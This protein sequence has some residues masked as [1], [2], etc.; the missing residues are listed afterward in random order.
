MKAHIITI[1]NEIL[2]G[3]I[4]DSNSAF[5]GQ[6]L[7]EIG[8]EVHQI[9]SISDD[10]AHI[11][12]TLQQN[13]AEIVILTGGLGPTKDDITKKTLAQFFDCDLIQNES[14]LEHIQ[15]LFKEVYKREM[16]ALN[17]E[18][19]LVPSCATVLFNTI[20]T[21]SGMWFEK[22]NILYISLPGV[23]FEMKKLLTEEVL[24]RI[25]KQFQLPYIIQRN[26]LVINTPES[27]LS[28]ILND[29]EDALPKHFSLA[30][31]PSNG[32]IRLRLMAK[33]GNKVMLEEEMHQQL[34]SLQEILGNKI[35]SIQGESIEQL[36][37]KILVEKNH[38]LAVAESCTGGKISSL[39]TQI[40]GASQYYKGAITSYATEAKTNL[41][42]V[43]TE[44]IHLHTVVSEEVAREMAQGVSEQ[45]QTTIGL[46]I[47]GVAGPN[48]GEDG[49]E[50]G[51]FCVAIHTDGNTHSKTFFIPNIPR[52]DFI[53]I[54]AKRAIDFLYQS[55]LL[56]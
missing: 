22:N 14:L 28:A 19:A 23:P 24:P 50:V 31:L 38:T 45:L 25:Q 30:Y 54:A 26:V 21:A 27:T 17:Q 33:A 4:I 39:I 46:S 53:E 3:Q 10:A 7:T 52:E 40:S 35:Q 12:Q 2:I 32:R 44:T 49:K 5:I 37:G 15:H 34:S 13:T 11:T 56:K 1:G 18:Q 20:G 43:S 6:Q 29:W 42:H 41:L 36:M 16:N 55:M 48:K 9:S 8:V 47:T 51:T